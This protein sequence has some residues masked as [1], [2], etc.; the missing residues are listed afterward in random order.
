MRLINSFEFK[1]RVLEE[2]NRRYP[3]DR[4]TAFA[5]AVR[6]GI[7]IALRCM[8]QTPTVEAEP[9]HY[10]WWQQTEDGEWECVSCKN[11]VTICVCGKDRTY[12]MERCPHCGA[13]MVGGKRCGE[14]LN[15]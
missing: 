4:D 12:R 1:Q 13:R 6:C 8:E 11:V 7:R 2:I 14:E 5:N 15:Q 10:S 9:A 3:K